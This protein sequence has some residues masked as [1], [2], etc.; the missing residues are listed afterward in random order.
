MPPFAGNE[1]VDLAAIVGIA[2]QMLRRPS[3]SDQGGT[4]PGPMLKYAVRLSSRW[5][6]P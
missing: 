1:D 4:A 2:C 5:P 3:D 6:N